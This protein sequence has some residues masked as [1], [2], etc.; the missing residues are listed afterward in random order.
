MILSASAFDNCYNFQSC[1][2]LYESAFA[3]PTF[4]VV[5]GGQILASANLNA[6]PEPATW[7][8]LTIGFA[9]LGYA[10]CRRR[11]KTPTVSA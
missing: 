7:A 3:D 5:G 10:A 9:G 4:T 1:P 11:L 8:M 6:V 2:V